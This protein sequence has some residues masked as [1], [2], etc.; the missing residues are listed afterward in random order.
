MSDKTERRGVYLYIDGKEISNNVAS[1]TSELRKIQKE[2]EKMTIG[3]EEY[4]NATRKIQTLKG[5]L[6]E[7]RAQLAAIN[8]E[9]K[10]GAGIVDKING[11]WGRYGTIIGGVVAGLTAFWLA[12]KGANDLKNP[13]EDAQKSLKALT[14]L[15]E[16]SIGWLTEEAKTLS[17]EMEKSGL[18]V[19]QSADEILQAFM[20]VGSAKPELLG[21]KQALKDVTVEAMRLSAASGMNLKPAVDALTLSLN[22]F[23]A[24]ASEAAKYANVL[25]AGSKAGAADVESVSKTIKN[26]GVAAATANVPIETLVGTIE[27]LAERGIKGEVA[28][29]GL[30]SF[31]LK[32]MQSADDTNPKVVGLTQALDN[33]AAKNL[34]AQQMVKMFG[35]EAY[36]V[37][38]SLVDMRSK[39]QSYTDAVTDTNVATEQAAINSETASA[40]LA[41]AGNKFKLAAIELADRLS[42]AL[43]VSTN[44]MVYIVKIM[45]AVIDFFVKWCGEIIAVVAAFVAY[46]VAVE[47]AAAK[48]VILTTATKAWT[49]ACTLGRA[50]SNLLQAAVYAMGLDFNLAATHISMATAEMK[51]LNLVMKLSPI[52]VFIAI[53]TGGV[54]AI[55]KFVEQ[56]NKFASAETMIAEAS[57]EAEKSIKK[58]K[59]AVEELNKKVHD[60]NLSYD[61]RKKALD[62]LK[63][64]VPGYKADLTDEGK[65][66]NDNIDALHKYNF[67]LKKEAEIKMIEQQIQRKKL[68]DSMFLSFLGSA[69]GTAGTSWTT[70]EQRIRVIDEET[71]SLKELE[72]QLEKVKKS[73]YQP[74]TKPVTTP[75]T[76]TEQPTGGSGGG[77]G[78]KPEKES[79]KQKRVRLAL[80]AIDAE[81]NA[82]A[83]EEKKRYLQGEYDTEAEYQQKLQDLEIQALDKKLEILELE[84]KQREEF[85][86]KIQDIKIRLL[87][88]LKDI[89]DTEAVT[90][91]EQLQKSLE[92]NRKKEAEELAIIQSARDSELLTEEEFQLKMQAVRKKWA[93][94]NMLLM[95]SEADRK[96]KQREEEFN[97]EL[98]LIAL[99]SMKAG[100]SEEVRNEKILQAQRAFYEELLK[101]ETI[102]LEKRN[103]IQ[104]SLDQLNLKKLEENYNEIK[105]KNRALFDSMSEL[106]SGIGEELAK[107]ITDS[108]VKLG[109]FAKSVIKMTLD[110]LEKVMQAAI[111]ERTIKNIATLGFWGIAKAAGEIALITAAFETAK[112]VIGNFWT[113]GYTGPGA[114][115]EPR[116]TVH[117]GEFVANRFAVANPNVRPVLD[118]IDHAQRTNTVNSLTSSDIAAV[119]S[120]NMHGTTADTGDKA[121]MEV[122]A[123]CENA[124]L[125]LERRL[126]IPIKAITTITGKEGWANTNSIYEQIMVNKSR[127]K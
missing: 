46:K 92:A 37:A 26:A 88:K 42:P 43:K 59:E 87:N 29:T 61:E 116:G 104:D 114:W 8:N 93:D 118:L 6:A 4:V 35:M 30:R 54:Y 63:I 107:F 102:S 99:E 55:A 56:T 64:K 31:L 74:E 14:G 108:E 112:A 100:E 12:Y 36:T 57:A 58:Q 90:E 34:N 110:T 47:V 115:N 113:G 82:K 91:E 40:V 86:A 84:P 97:H 98:S 83:T 77:G 32:L 95:Q 94:K 119:S 41:Q 80:A 33:L 24:D 96:V 23:G 79:E 66:I 52:G 120:K 70:V 16:G 18:R 124:I 126:N 65:L 2:Q 1:I 53:I 38:Q 5:I 81:F 27:T 121:M 49:V 68:A 111:A 71:K 19:R 28:G 76:P 103:E 44:S 51:A 50:A 11:A 89:D 17:T 85:A 109:D 78:G 69:Q 25:A 39:V 21:D 60:G 3:S 117:A 75:V 13:L 15:D 20:L 122:I 10:K 105:E 73:E 125:H 127:N 7:H 72:E 9:Q 101:D 123:H 62:E 22:M 67:E 45:P 48:T 106:G